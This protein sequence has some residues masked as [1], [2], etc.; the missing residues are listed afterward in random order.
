MFI[1]PLEGTGSGATAAA[2]GGLAGAVISG[3]TRG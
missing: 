1:A 2:E 3:L